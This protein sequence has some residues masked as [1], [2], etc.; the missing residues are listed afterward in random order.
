MA[1]HE[2]RERKRQEK[3]KAARTWLFSSKIAECP[4]SSCKHALLPV[5]PENTLDSNPPGPPPL[6]VLTRLATSKIS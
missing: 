4:P 2:W 1:M 6:P 5:S 3:G